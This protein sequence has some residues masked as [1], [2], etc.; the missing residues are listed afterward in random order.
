MMLRASVRRGKLMTR[1][2]SSLKTGSVENK[3]GGTFESETDGR[4]DRG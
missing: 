3:K 4:G 1:R 2:P